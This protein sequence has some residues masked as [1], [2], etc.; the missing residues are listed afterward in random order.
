MFFPPDTI[1]LSTQEVSSHSRSEGH[2][3]NHSIVNVATAFHNHLLGHISYVS[4][5]SNPLC[6]KAVFAI[7]EVNKTIKSQETASLVTVPHCE[8]LS[9]SDI[10]NI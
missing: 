2:P 3:E 8:I 9:K 1:F 7:S 10:I 4:P 5:I 6:F